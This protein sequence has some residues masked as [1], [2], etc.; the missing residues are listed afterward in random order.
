MPTEIKQFFDNY[1]DAFNR[2][3]GRGVSAHY[4]VPSMI[5]SSASEGLFVD[6]DALIANNTALC[7]IYRDNGFVRADYAE[8]TAIRQGDDFFLADFSWTIQWRDKPAQQFNTTY[9]LVKRGAENRAWKIEHVTAYSEKQFW[10][11]NH[12]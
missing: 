7:E 4:H 5:S 1:R 10:K 11:A 2:L 3:D 12:D 9:Q 8:N 6:V